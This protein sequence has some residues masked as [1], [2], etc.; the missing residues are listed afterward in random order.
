MA[1]LAVTAS[2]GPARAALLI[3]VAVVLGAGE[4]L[5]LPASFSVVPVVTGSAAFLIEA[6]AIA[7]TPFP[8]RCRLGDCSGCATGSAT[9]TRSRRPASP[10][11]P[12]MAHRQDQQR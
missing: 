12:G 9:P 11:R 6:V 1:A 4:G 3:P 5:F 8:R 7:A 10:R 2:A